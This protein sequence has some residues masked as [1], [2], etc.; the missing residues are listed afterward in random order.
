MKF[1]GIIDINEDDIKAFG[2]WIK[3]III[4][5]F[6]PRNKKN[7]IGIIIAIKT[8]NEKERTRIQNDIIIDLKQYLEKSNKKSLF[9]VIQLSN[10]HANKIIEHNMA[11][12]YIR[13]IRGHLIIYGSVCE[14]KVKGEIYYCFRLEG[15]VIHRPIPQVVSNI[16]GQEFA[17]FMP[18]RWQF[19]ESDEL[20]GFDITQQWVGVVVKYIIGIASYVSFDFEFAWDIFQQIKDDIKK[21]NIKNIPTLIELNKRLSLRLADVA[22]VFCQLS[23]YAYTRSR[24]I[25]YIKKMKEYLDIIEKYKPEDYS[26]HNLRAMYLFLVDKNVD[27]A[28]SVYNNLVIKLDSTWR[29]NLAFLYAYRGQLNKAKIQYDKAFSGVIIKDVLNDTEKF[30]SE[31]IA[32]EPEKYQLFFCRGYIFYKAK[33]DYTA[34]KQDFENFIIKADKEYYSEFVRLVSIY[35]EHITRQI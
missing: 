5:L 27:G 18:R 33:K 23:Y 1:F 12:K 19:P 24:N 11:I 21:I 17:S 3:E 13:R 16:F 7:K 30:I 22:S 6:I 20:L 25:D 4:R 28:I 35:I 10:Y 32:S 14:R 2:R 9:N 29:Y 26:A 15:S 8:E 31:T 34:A